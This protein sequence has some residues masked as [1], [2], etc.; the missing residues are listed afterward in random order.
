MVTAALR[1]V[2]R[3]ALKRGSM[4]TDSADA[5][6]QHRRCAKK[7]PTRMLSPLF[8]RSSIV[9]MVRKAGECPAPALPVAVGWSRA[10]V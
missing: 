3:R 9:C 4:L 2:S 6:K 8:T 1:L 7:R 5:G 10:E